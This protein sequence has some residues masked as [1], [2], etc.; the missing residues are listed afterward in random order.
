[1]VVDQEGM[2]TGWITKVKT[3]DEILKEKLFLHLPQLAALMFQSH[4][5]EL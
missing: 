1:M 5:S 3:V 4:L 2:K